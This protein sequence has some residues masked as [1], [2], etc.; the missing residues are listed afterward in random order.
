LQR[1]QTTFTPLAVS[2][3]NS[4]CDFRVPSLRL[5]RWDYSEHPK[6]GPSGFQMVISRTLFVS[7]I[8]IAFETRSEVFSAS[9]DRFVMNKIFFYDP[10]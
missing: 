6:A 3:N 7:G 10:Y 8:Q 4:D 9:L 1:T 5:E 2:E